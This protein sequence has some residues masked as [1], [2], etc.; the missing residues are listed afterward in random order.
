MTKIQGN[1]W[2]IKLVAL[3]CLCVDVFYGTDEIRPGGEALNFAAHAADFERMDVTLLGVVGDDRYAKTIMSSIADRRIDTHLVRVDKNHNTANNMTY[4]TPEGD[5]YYKEDSWDGSILDNIVLNEE[6]ISAI[7]GADVVF[8]HFAASCFK[9]V[10]ELRKQADFKLAVDFDVEKDFEK[11]EQYASYIDFFMISGAKELLPYF[12]DFSK[13]YDGLFNMPLAEQGSVTYHKGVKY[14][15]AAEPV[16]KIVD[17]TG[18]G[19]SYH[20]GFVCSYLLEG[21]IEKAMRTGS[22]TAARTLSHYGGF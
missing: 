13:K 9:Q 11:I 16:E 12:E 5:R 20:A 10:W 3:P 19:D 8:V 6:E 14:Q 4:L 17:T 1:E 15:V 18:C 7:T 22:Q 2:K 21:D